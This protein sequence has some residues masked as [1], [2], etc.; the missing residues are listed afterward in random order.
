MSVISVTLLDAPFTTSGVANLA[1]AAVATTNLATWLVWAGSNASFA[2]ANRVTD[3]KG[4]TWVRVGTDGGPAFT[5]FETCWKCEG[6]VGGAGHIVTVTPDAGGVI[7]FFWVELPPGS[8]VDRITTPLDKVGTPFTSNP[9]SALSQ[10]I[11]AAIAFEFDDRSSG[12][13]IAWGN[14]YTAL[15]DQSATAGV[16]AA[17]AVLITASTAAQSS[18][19]TNAQ[20]S[21]AVSRVV[22]LKN[23]GDAAAGAPT[24]PVDSGD[25]YF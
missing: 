15:V 2:T 8:V 10:A 5:V 17:A 9:T 24:Y 16:T 3:N 23:P 20:T 11:E 13:A 7:T 14:G 4:N 12:T 21:E 6:G 18:T 1:S 19:F 22:T 25:Q